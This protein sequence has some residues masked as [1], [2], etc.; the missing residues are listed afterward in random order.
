[1]ATRFELVLWGDHPVRLRALGEE[2][3][4]EIDRIENLLSLYR[5][6]TDIARINAAPPGTRVRVAPETLRLLRHARDLSRLTQGT[7][8]PTAG[9]LIRAWGF[10]QGSG[11]PPDPESLRT[12]L[13]QIGWDRIEFD[14][15]AGQVTRRCE[16]LLLDLGA[17]GKGYALD[18]ASDL[19]REG[20]VTCALLQGGTSSVVA[21]GNPPDAEG[22]KIALPASPEG[23]PAPLISLSNSSLSVSAPSGKGFVNSD[24][25]YLGHVLD[26]RTGRPVSAHTFVAVVTDQATDSDALSTALLVGGTP[27]LDGLQEAMGNLRVW[28]GPGGSVASSP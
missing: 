26:P 11:Q 10:H 16:G 14:D 28:F 18:R 9:A 5:P 15:D 2:A 24:G 13:D 1:M 19:V 22:W 7:F 6:H 20:G 25:Q 17:I 3:L 21:L 12:A 23:G 27:V 4:D 8:D